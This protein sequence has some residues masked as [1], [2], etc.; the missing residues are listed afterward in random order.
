MRTIAKANHSKKYTFA[1]ITLSFKKQTNYT[2]GES[3]FKFLLATAIR[4]IHGDVANEPDVLSFKP[5]NS[6]HY[7]SI[8]RF[9][10]IHH[11]RIITSLLLFGEW[12]NLECKFELYKTAPTPCFLSI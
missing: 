6:Q 3:E 12:K 5:T 4:S 11:A 10:T 2:L 8:I 9:K 7:S 1:S